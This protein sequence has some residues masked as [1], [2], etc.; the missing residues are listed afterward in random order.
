[1]RSIRIILE[2]LMEHAFLRE[3]APNREGV[4]HSR[5]LG[6]T[7]EGHHLTQIMDQASQMKPVFIRMSFSYPF[8]SLECM[9]RVWKACL[10]KLIVKRDINYLYNNNH[11]M[12]S[13]GC[14][15][16]VE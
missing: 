8:S 2:Q 5:P 11:W 12:I 1:M 6:L 4:T 9:E 14:I 7:I 16:V 3:L 15:E 10:S 13:M